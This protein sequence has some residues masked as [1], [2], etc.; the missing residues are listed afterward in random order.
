MPPPKPTQ[1]GKFRPKKPQK[2][3]SK[4][5]STPATTGAAAPSSS[6]PIAVNSSS[7]TPIVRNTAPIEHSGGRGRGGR[8]GRGRGRGGR[9][10]GRGRIPIPQGTVFFTGGE[11]KPASTAKG[12]ASK[13]ST[14]GSSGASRTSKK[15]DDAKGKD[16]KEVM[17]ASTE[18]VVGQLDTA[19]GGTKTAKKESVLERDYG[20]YG[21]DEGPK[22]DVATSTNLNISAGCMYD[23]DSS[24]EG[25]TRGPKLSSLIAPLELPFSSKSSSKAIQPDVASSSHVEEEDEDPESEELASPFVVTEDAEDLREEKNSWFL[26]Q[27]PT[28][29]PPMQK[30]FSAPEND[31]GD[32]METDTPDQSSTTAASNALANIS[33]VAVPPVTTSSFDHGLDKNA[34]GMIGKILVYKSGKTVLVLDG[35]DDKVT[36]NVHEG[37]TCSFQQQAVAV[38]VE[39]GQYITLGDVNKSIVVSPDLTGI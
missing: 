5:I 23:S 15:S 26:V 28:R 6:A 4:P 25:S 8:G 39:K 30:A 27:L 34:P 20:D 11:K 22:E 14:S 29:L 19:I 33:E 31:N 36:M 24:D 7:D 37:L 9:G 16:G 38:N 35:P 21:N 3:I 13:R 2:K 17:D 18:E 10:R 12:S 1:K 32:T